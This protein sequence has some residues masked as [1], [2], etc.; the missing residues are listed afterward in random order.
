MSRDPEASFRLLETETSWPTQEEIWLLTGRDQHHLL[1][2][3]ESDLK[4]RFLKNLINIQMLLTRYQA[5]L[6]VLEA[7]THSIES[8]QQPY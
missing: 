6:S 3:A 1:L 4:E 2:L 5:L 7:L 8:S